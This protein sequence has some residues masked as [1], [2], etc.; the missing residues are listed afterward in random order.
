ME[1][2]ILLAKIIGPIYLVIAAGLLLNQDHFRAVAKEVASSPAL[3]YLTGVLALVLGMLI[4]RFHNVW[5]GWPAVITILGWLA[6]L[7]GVVRVVTPDRAR[8]MV[9][10]M[11]GNAAVMTGAVVIAFALGAFLT[12][13]GYGFA[14]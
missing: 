6:V 5:T 13:M 12:A 10:R 7:R 14:G 1:T 4:V 3:F 9:S 8:E 2:S 11:T